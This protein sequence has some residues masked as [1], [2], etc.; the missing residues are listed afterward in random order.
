M[1]YS[2]RIDWYHEFKENFSNWHNEGERV[3]REILQNP[4]H[5]NFSQAVEFTE[6]TEKEAKEMRHNRLVDSLL[7]N[8][9]LVPMMNY[10]YPLDI[11]PKDKDIFEV[12]CETNCTVMYDYENDQFYLALTGGGMDLSQDIALAYII[13]QKWVP[14][15]LAINVNTQKNL[16]VHGKNWE[17]VKEGV[18]NSLKSDRKRAQNKIERWSE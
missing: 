14:F 10:G 11:N 17:K 6:Y 8:E 15:D 7:E 9:Y 2:V 4:D 5:E 16:S 1:S 18:I 13:I 12:V 3:V